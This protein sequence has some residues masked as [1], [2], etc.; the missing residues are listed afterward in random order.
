MVKKI[1]YDDHSSIVAALEGQQVLIITMAVTAPR[2]QE[3]K[4]IKAAADANV[5]FVLPNEWGSDPTRTALVNETLLGPG[6]Q[7][8]REMVEEFGKSSWIAYCCGFWYEYSLGGGDKRYGFDMNNRKLTYFD[9]GTTR[10][11]TSTWPQAA[12][13]VARLLSLKVLPDD[14]NDKSKTLSSF[15]NNVCY[16]NSFLLNQQEMFESVK[17]VTGTSDSDWTITHENSKERYEEGM[18]AMKGGDMRGFAQLLY[19]RYFY[20]SD[21]GNFSAKA[22]NELLGLPKEDLDA[23]TKVAIGLAETGALDEATKKDI[24]AGK[25]QLQST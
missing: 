14:E 9:D 25:H 1:N 20:P 8:H 6:R 15:K 22:N 19:T 11:T 23:A 12:L 4:L 7:K 13:G 24:K 3:G 2:E 16:V 21:A 18:K 17:R 5:E 10:I